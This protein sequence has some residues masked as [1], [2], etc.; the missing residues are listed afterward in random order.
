MTATASEHV[1]ARARELLGRWTHD[2]ARFA[3][4]VLKA[5]LWSRQEEILRA[6][7]AHDRVA[8]RSGHK[9]GKSVTAAMLALWWVCTRPRA[10]VAMTSATASQVRRILWRELSIWYESARYPIGGQLNEVPASGLS[11]SDKREVFGFSTKEAERAAGISGDNV[12]F[13]VDEASG[14]AEKIFEALEGNRA[15]GA[16][17]V[18]FSNPTQQ[19][20]TFFEAF[21]AKRDLWHC[22]H[23]SS[24]EAAA[25]TPRIPGLATREWVRE[26]EQDWGRESP[27]FAVRVGGDFAGQ[28]PDSVI[29]L[30]V[31]SGA[32]ARFDDVTSTGR[33]ECGLDAAREGDDDSELSLIR[34]DKEIARLTLPKGDGPKVARAAHAAV[35]EHRRDDEVPR[36]KV[37]VIGVGAS[38]Y[39]ALKVM[40]GVEVV[41][42]NVA[43]VADPSVTEEKYHNLRAQLWFGL[44]DWL[45]TG[46]IIADSKREG[47]LVAPRYGYDARGCRQVEAKESIKKRLKRSP[48]RAEALMLAVYNP[49][50]PPPRQAREDYY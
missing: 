28:A 13:I 32:V 44:G 3:R 37:D 50:A 12:L 8:I 34:G 26:K 15:G 43:N 14:V 21:H 33:L 40:P 10:R 45:K 23:V 29:G 22:I 30:V 11:F 41:P 16:K 5:R 1:K 46:A 19:S 24:E 20:G 25:V 42:V 18:M 48:D 39:D 7:D 36:I 9:I 38:V 35:M 2:P 27:I 17:I 49:P 4:E 47:E 6:V 31:V